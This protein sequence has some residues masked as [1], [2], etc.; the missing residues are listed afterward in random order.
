MIKKTVNINELYQETA[1][2]PVGGEDVA[3][4]K[5]YNRMLGRLLWVLDCDPT[6]PDLNVI[7]TTAKEIKKTRNG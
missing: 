5:L 1:L 7:V 3:L 4:I 2:L 6:D